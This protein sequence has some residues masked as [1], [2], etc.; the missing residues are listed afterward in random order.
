VLWPVHVA[1]CL[2]EALRIH[3]AEDKGRVAYKVGGELGQ[4]ERVSGPGA[5]LAGC[6][7]V[8]RWL[9]VKA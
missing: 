8:V 2:Q 1:C 3:K 5:D 9:V 7:S 4:T 6:Y